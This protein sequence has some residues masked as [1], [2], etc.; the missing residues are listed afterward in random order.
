MSS[1]SSRQPVFGQK[2]EMLK[3]WRRLCAKRLNW[4]S[5]RLEVLIYS[6]NMMFSD[7]MQKHFWE[8]SLSSLIIDIVI[9]L[10]W[11]CRVILMQCNRWHMSFI[12]FFISSVRYYNVILLITFQYRYITLLFYTNHSK[13][14]IVLSYLV[15][16]FLYSIIYVKLLVLFHYLYFTYL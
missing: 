5:C 7:K 15:F 8:S 14:N 3:L 9:R 2:S 4:Q 16:V 10:Y 6:W 13:H 11:Y 12:S 1:K